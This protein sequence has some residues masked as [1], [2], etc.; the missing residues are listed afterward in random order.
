MCLGIAGRGRGETE[1][2]IHDH[3]ADE[4]PAPGTLVDQDAALKVL[5]PPKHATRG[6]RHRLYPQYSISQPSNFR[7]H[8]CEKIWMYVYIYAR[9]IHNVLV[10]NLLKD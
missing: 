9:L 2:S 7:Q 4:D 6:A 5:Q 10:D 1:I 8:S 3:G